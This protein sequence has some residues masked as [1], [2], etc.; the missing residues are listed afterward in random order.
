MNVIR[1]QSVGAKLWT[2]VAIVIVALI[3]VIAVTG[4]KSA[5]LS[6]ESDQVLTQM[7]EKM[8]LATRWVGLIQ[9]NV[10]RVQASMV[11]SDPA[12]DALY[13]D[14]VAAT[15]KEI[16]EV[17]RRIE[18]MPLSPR[19]KALLERI[20]ADRKAVLEPLAK[21]RELKN[22]GDAEGASREISS[23]FNP[24]L[25]PYYASLDEFAR[26]QGSIL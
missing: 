1:Q 20:A 4:V 16:T 10:T 7:S 11:S 3:A 25:L 24:A 26:L 13:K 19:E 14:Q 22:A 5:S 2:G 23:R 17:Q 9:T 18:G 21:A 15:V 12:V 6:R 8:Q